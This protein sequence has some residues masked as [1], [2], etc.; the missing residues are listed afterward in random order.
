[1]PQFKI[2]LTS[3]Y[4]PQ[5]DASDTAAWGRIRI[6]KFPHSHLGQEDKLLKGRMTQ[7]DSLEGILAWIAR[8]AKLWYTMGSDGLKTPQLVKKATEE[9]RVDV[10]WVA[11]WIAEVVTKTDDKADKV[12]S[13]IYYQEYR[14]WCTENGVSPK[15]LRS[16][17]RSLRDGGFTI[18]QPTWIGNKTKRCW[19]GVKV[20]GYSAGLKGMQGKELE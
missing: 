7:Q 9:A 16:L 17:N 2:W 19:I 3:N 10:D 8:G 13:D 11:T 12:P 14:D 5:M 20:A 15:S 4:P 1:M 18:G 6:V